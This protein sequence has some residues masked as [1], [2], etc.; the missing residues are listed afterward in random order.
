MYLNF[1][2]KFKREVFEVYD[3][4]YYVYG[5]GG[6]EIEG[7]DDLKN[8]VITIDLSISNIIYIICKK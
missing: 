2:S 3:F 1:K 6:N 4:V 8:V 5:N 7:L